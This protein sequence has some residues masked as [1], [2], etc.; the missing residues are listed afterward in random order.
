MADLKLRVLME[1]VDRITGPFRRA[2]Q[3][4]GGLKESVGAAAEKLRSLE[5]TARQMERFRSLKTAARENDAALAAAKA[6]ASQLARA[7]AETGTATKAMQREFQRATAEVRKLESASSK[8]AAE[9]HRMRGELKGAGVETRQ[10][11]SE[12]RRMKGEIAAATAAAEREAAALERA[13]QRAKALAA[14]KSKLD[15]GLQLQANASFVGAAG[16]ATGGAA[17][18]VG[19][20]FLSAGIDFEK[21]MDKVASLA[22]IDEASDAF[23]SLEKQAMQLGATTSFSASQIADGMGVLAMAGFNALQITKSM[24]GM[25]DLAKAA[26]TDLTTATDISAKILSAFEYDASQMKD[27]GDVLVA[28]FT[29]SNTSLE[30]LGDTLKYVAPLAKAAGYSLGDVSVLTGLLGNVGI[31]ASESG[32]AQKAIIARL[33]G[34]PAEA[35]KVLKKLGVVTKDA[36]GNMLPL[37]NVL[38]EIAAKT[39]HLGTG[40]LL[41]LMTKLFGLEAAS[42]GVALVQKAGADGI[43]AFATQ[44]TDVAKA[45]ANA[46]VAKQM[47]DNAAGDIDS[48]KSALEGVSITLTKL[49]VSP[50][51]GVIQTATEAVRGVNAWMEANP[52]LTATL[53]QVAIY[54]GMPAG[55]E[56]FRLAREVLREA[57][58]D[59]GSL[60]EGP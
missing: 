16:M 26:D 10:L 31:Q 38:A 30:M 52:R 15:K 8:N 50:L 25:L 42:A 17:L 46:N 22:R 54:C 36:A 60:E 37:K 1:A 56:A 5:A 44:V 51:R 24:P 32:T 4:A 11:A 49:N 34:P 47:G 2:R 39:Q 40:D 23:K 3:S 6:K 27:V 12:T 20:G 29:Q 28:T 45:G 14:A 21:A 33:A 55:V 13:T 35:A 59:V 58:V 53:M 7:M 18:G 41:D 43:K 57:G 48:F 9:L 19:A